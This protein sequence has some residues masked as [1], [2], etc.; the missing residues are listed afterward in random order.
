[1]EQLE[2]E[3]TQ[4]FGDLKTYDPYFEYHIAFFTENLDHYLTAF[5]ELPHFVSTF[6]DPLSG[7]EFASLL[8]QA[9]GSLANNAGSLIAIELLGAAS[10]D[11]LR[12][13][14]K[15]YKHELPRA[16]P[17]SLARAADHLSVAPR[18]LSADGKP[19]ITPVHLSFASSDLD[20]DVAWFQNVIKGEK[21]Y[22]GTTS[23]EKVFY[24]KVLGTDG[25]EVRYVQSASATRGPVSVAEWEKYQTD[26]H[27]QCFDMDTNQGFDRLADN[28]FGHALGQRVNLGPYI[29][30]QQAAG[31]P[32]RFY[33]QQFFY[34]Y[35][36]NGW[37]VQLIG[38][39]PSCQG[40]GYDMC[41]QGITGHCKRDGAGDRKSVV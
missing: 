29:E 19:V 16:S 8:V 9:P 10:S 41:T 12:Q 34:A 27:A 17:Q 40:G 22:E 5:A 25:T 1:M 4:S 35:G 38:K 28:H 36:P 32:Y 31:L 23:E 11:L 30:A 33:S 21:V 3:F 20:R 24:G 18:K 14:R 7:T 15:I 13:T 26:L 39:C 37:G 2:M 6:T